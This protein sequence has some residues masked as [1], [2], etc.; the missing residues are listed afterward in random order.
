[1]GFA[2]AVGRPCRQLVRRIQKLAQTCKDSQIAARLRII[3]ADYFSLLFQIAHLPSKFESARDDVEVTARAIGQPVRV[4]KA[5][6]EGS[7]PCSSVPFKGRPGGTKY[8]YRSNH[9]QPERKHPQTRNRL[10]SQPRQQ[11]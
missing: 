8:S 2:A 3:A 5:G 6:N 4:L 1:A 7:R 10:K 9:Q 11:Q